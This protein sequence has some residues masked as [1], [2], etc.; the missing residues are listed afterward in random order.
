M[1]DQ[2]NAA[3]NV[4]FDKV[5]V[6]AFLSKAAEL[7]ISPANDEELVEMLKIAC[8]LRYQQQH[9]VATQSGPSVV[10]AAAAELES[11]VT[12]ATANPAADLA[13]DPDVS[14]ALSQLLNQQ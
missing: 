13:S 7:N 6:P 4:L 3:S 8:L 5:Y 9:Q 10:K 1:S 14:Q 11:M 2:Q 12:A